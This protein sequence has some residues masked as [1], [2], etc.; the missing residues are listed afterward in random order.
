VLPDQHRQGGGARHSLHC[1]LGGGGGDSVV[2]GANR[3]QGPQP[4]VDHEHAPSIQRRRSH[5]VGCTD[6]TADA[7]DAASRGHASWECGNAHTTTTA[8]T[9]AAN[10]AV[11]DG[12]LLSMGAVTGDDLH[13]LKDEETARLRLAVRTYV[14]LYAHTLYK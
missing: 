8:A 4:D 5:G 14:Q 1:C 2:Q 12:S 13:E 10:S 3:E 11:D 6:D 9:A 7:V